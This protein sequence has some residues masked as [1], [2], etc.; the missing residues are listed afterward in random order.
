MIPNATTGI[1]NILRDFVYDADGRDEILYFSTIYGACGK[2][3]NYVAEINRGLVQPREVKLTYPMSD[4]DLVATFK[5]AISASRAARKVPRLA[6]FDTVS[7]NPGLRIPYEQLTKVCKEEGV[8]S[9]ID[10]AH[11]VGHV[12]LDLSALDPDFFVSNAHKWLFVPRGCCVFYVPVRNQEMIRSS[13]PTSHGFVPKSGSG[14]TPSSMRQPEHSEFVNNFEFVGTIDNTSYL[15]VE[16]AIKWRQQVCGGEEA[17]IEYNSRLAQEGGKLIAKILGTKTL[18]NAEKTLTDC[19]MVNV[20]LPL[21]ISESPISGTNTVNPAKVADVTLWTQETLMKEHNTFIAIGY[22]QGQWWARLSGQVYLDIED[23][24][25]AAY[26]L[27]EICE[28][29]GKEESLN[30]KK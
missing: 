2:T 22:T 14:G 20:L 24:E 13:L 16:E 25:W 17:I 12:P 5:A 19:C 10:G 1:N 27:K 4:S 15:V 23:F 9:V 18:D 21:E 30:T 29:A 3:V 28:R 6:I 8:L 11:G 26:R 7:S